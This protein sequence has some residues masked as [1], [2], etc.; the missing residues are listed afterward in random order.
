MK[1]LYIKPDAI[2]ELLE[3]ED[4]LTASEED[5]IENPSGGGTPLEF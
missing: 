5:S 4:I 3:K 2:I 1:E